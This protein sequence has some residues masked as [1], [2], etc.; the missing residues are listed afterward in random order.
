M[1]E[2]AFVEVLEVIDHME[3]NMTKQIPA[4]VIKAIM[5]NA[6]KDYKYTYDESKGLSEQK[7]SEDAQV[8]LSVLFVKYIANDK[9]KSEIENLITENEKKLY[10]V[11]K[12][13]EPKKSI[14]AEEIKVEELNEEKIIEEINE[15]VQL[16]KKSDKWYTKIIDFIKNI[17][18]KK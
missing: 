12:K 7:I 8:I 18:S 17:F 16:V 13:P 4:E 5:S 9:E 14:Q 3:S 15:S 1:Y 6:D 10:D 11:F 2:K